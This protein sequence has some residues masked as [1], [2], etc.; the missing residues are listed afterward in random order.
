MSEAAATSSSA[1]SSSAYTDSTVELI[2]S[3][4]HRLQWD[5][6]VLESEHRVLKDRVALLEGESSRAAVRLSWLERF[7]QRFRNF[8][9][10]F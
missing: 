1:R 5:H 8:L 3:H 4:L 2:S 10:G 9:A 7:V 6:D